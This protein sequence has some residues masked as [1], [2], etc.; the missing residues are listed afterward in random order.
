[1]VPIQRKIQITSKATAAILFVF[2]TFAVFNFFSYLYFFVSIVVKGETVI[3]YGPSSTYYFSSDQKNLMQNASIILGKGV[4]M[5]LY[6]AVFVFIAVLFLKMSRTYT[7]FDGKQG[8]YLILIAI[9]LFAYVVLPPLSTY[10]A[11]AALVPNFFQTGHY[12]EGGFLIP[13]PFM[14]PRVFLL[15][16]PIVL[17]C[18]GL[19]CNYGRSLQQLADETL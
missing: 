7:P 13:D 11:M 8:K 10:C 3:P 17:Y 1:M 15:T 19:I 9:F 16:F 18:L 4:E 14:S 6:A 5:L 12:S 2:F